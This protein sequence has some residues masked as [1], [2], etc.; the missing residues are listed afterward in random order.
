MAITLKSLQRVVVDSSSA[1]DFGGY[2]VGDP[3]DD[4]MMIFLKMPEGGPGAMD[5]LVDGVNLDADETVTF[6]YSAAMVQPT[7]GDPTF[8]VAVRWRRR[9]R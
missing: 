6:V 2:Y 1:S 8:G 3:D 7:T 4:E 9:S 5:V